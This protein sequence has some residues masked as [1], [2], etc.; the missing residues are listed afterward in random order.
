MIA[1]L[2]RSN[3]YDT[4]EVWSEERLCS[5]VAKRPRPDAPRK[6]AADLRLE[7]ERLIALAH[8][9]I[10]R[11]YELLE[12]DDGPTLIMETLDGETV[13]H[14]LAGRRL[15]TD[16]VAWLG[17][18]V[19]SALRYLHGRGLLHVDV[20]PGNLIAT[21]GRAVLIDLSM[22]RPP[23]RYRR[24]LGT[25]CN[26][27]P[28][29]ARG[30]E[31]TAAADVWGL[32]TVLLEAAHGAPAFPQQEPEF[33]QLVFPPPLVDGP[34]GDVI[35][36]CLAFDPFDRPTLPELAAA[37]LPHAPGA[38]PWSDPCAATS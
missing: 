25:W 20:K 37:L 1:H 7:G 27:S 38:R 18:Q 16:E 23:G 8:P 15:D 28:E 12:T 13:A 26:L 34:L 17:L 2:N 9:H 5:C 22:A 35:A 21:G 30:D 3:R 4:Y 24:G 6:T 29:Q 11:G 14:L 31:L 10:V 36:A 33:P 19:A 32:G